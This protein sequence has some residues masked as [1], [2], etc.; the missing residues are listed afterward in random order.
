MGRRKRI[1][2]PAFGQYRRVRR[3]GQVLLG[4]GAEGRRTARSARP[5]PL[6]P[7]RGRTDPLAIS[8][9]R[10]VHELRAQ[11]PI[12]PPSFLRITTVAEPCLQAAARFILSRIGLSA[13]NAR[14]AATKFSALATQN[15]E[16][17]PPLAASTL[18]KGTSNEAVPLAV[19]RSPA[20]AA[21]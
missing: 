13:T 2:L 10:A 6:R 15:T 8:V 17:Q 19:Y 11:I 9:C 14:I 3:R 12:T 18:L 16:C 20:L 4:D 7:A 1:R 5:R 21:A